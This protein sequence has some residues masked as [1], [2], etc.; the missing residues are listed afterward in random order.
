MPM[1]ATITTITPII[2]V[3]GSMFSFSFHPE[4]LI[5]YFEKMA[6]KSFV[7]LITARTIATLIV[8]FT[9]SIFIIPFLFL[10]Q[11]IPSF[12]NFV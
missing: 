3:L 5:S 2:T 6:N 12:G 9:I 8:K 11:L 1:I 4:N 10:Q 7:C